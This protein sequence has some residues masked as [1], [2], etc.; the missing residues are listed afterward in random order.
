[1]QDYL[2][3]LPEED[4]AVMRR[5]LADP[6]LNE[7][8]RA[9]LHFGLAQVLDA[10]N[11][12]DEA[13]RHATQANSLTLAC[14]R[15]RGRAYDPTP[16][17][18]FVDRLLATFTPDYFEHVRGF[19]VDS[20][21]PVFI[22]G[23]PGSGTTL[24]EQVLASHSQVFGTG[25]QHLARADFGMLA[26]ESDESRAFDNLACLDVATV[27]CLASRHLERLNALNGT[28][29][30]IVDKIPDSYL[31]LGLLATL[32]PNATF[33]HCRRDLRDVAV[34]CWMTNFRNV[35]W[36]SDPDHLAARFH[37]YQRLMDHWRQVLPVPILE[38]DYEET[39]ADL[40]GVA[41]WLV[42]WCGLEWEPAC[43][44]FHEA[45]HSV[46]TASFAQVCQP[47]CTRS[48]A[49]WKNYET[50]LA[51]L[52][53]QLP[54]EAGTYGGV[55]TRGSAVMTWASRRWNNQSNSPN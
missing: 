10:R 3:K 53:E 34:S 25:K 16:H 48:V 20:D 44:A 21:R 18:E 6:N 32:F 13:A 23:L 15:K 28:A 8:R 31:Y 2:E 14:Q 46:R 51:P 1:M 11:E 38:V 12:C 24:I 47:V 39:V 26:E 54:S 19:G 27:R 35:C 33:V 41:Q 5:L 43:M 7:V 55:Q 42:A 40:E 4:L 30:R 45:K 49:R 50:A 9:L 37:D 52:F 36:A 22:V 29:L 17:S